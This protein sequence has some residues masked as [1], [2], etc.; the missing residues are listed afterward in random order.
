M[1]KS[2]KLT[3]FYVCSSLVLFLVLIGG[4]IYGLYVSI[5]LNF[6]RSSGLDVQNNFDGVANV[7]YG[8]TVNFSLNMT[9]VIILSVV[10]ILLS[11]FDLIAM[12]KQIVFFKQFKFIANSKI[13]KMVERKTKSKGGVVFFVVLVDVLSLVAG[14]VGLIVN[15][16][17][18]AGGGVTW[19]LYLIDALIVLLS[20]TSLILL[21]MKLKKIKKF[22]NEN[23]QKVA[24]ESAQ[25]NDNIC[26]KKD[27]GFKNFNID[28]C[29]YL[30]LKLRHLKSSKLIS[31]EEY[32]DIRN[33]IFPKQNNN[34]ELN[35]IDE[36]KKRS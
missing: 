28:E 9:G 36:N 20:L 14:V 6:V 32:Q 8:G 15:L 25:N 2:N 10:L 7:S 4:G 12:I 11:I 18:L 3:A 33:K 16:R 19:V 22:Q 35:N 17:S 5:G 1:K 31:T 30:L 13:E 23:K 26:L 21:I 34:L 27:F 29:E 24:C